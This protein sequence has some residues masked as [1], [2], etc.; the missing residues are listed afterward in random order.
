MLF[1]LVLVWACIIFHVS[2][3]VEG[4]GGFFQRVA[5]LLLELR[6][7]LTEQVDLL[8]EFSAYCELVRILDIDVSVGTT[9]AVDNIQV[10]DVVDGCSLAGHA[11]DL[12]EVGADVFELIVRQALRKQELANVLADRL[13]LLV[14]AARGVLVRV[15]LVAAVASA[16]ET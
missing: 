6:S 2:A 3:H 4:S 12:L 5:S 11:I 13:V 10:F 8:S 15:R 1:E 16:I 9:C 7:V 14:V